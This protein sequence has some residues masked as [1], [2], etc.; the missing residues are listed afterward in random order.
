MSAVSEG[1]LAVTKDESTAHS[2]LAVLVTLPRGLLYRLLLIKHEIISVL[3]S[4]VPC[5]VILSSPTQEGPS[6][7]LPDE[8]YMAPVELTMKKLFL[9]RM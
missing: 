1:V 3:W 4:D 9:P 2:L 8:V 7:C 6:E 5:F